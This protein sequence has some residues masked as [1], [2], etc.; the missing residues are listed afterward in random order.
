V[1]SGDP[2]CI[3][4]FIQIAKRVQECR[5]VIDLLEKLN[6][7]KNVENVLGKDFELAQLKV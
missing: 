5:R 7:G 2:L 4:L 1:T 6:S 3:C